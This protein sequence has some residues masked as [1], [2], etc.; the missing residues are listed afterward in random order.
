MAA[1]MI[2]D[3]MLDSE[4]VQKRSVPARWL[5]L[6][7]LLSADDVG[8]FE[9]SHFKLHRAAA[10]DEKSIPVL[11][12][13]LAEADLIRPYEVSG[14]QFGFIPRFRQRLQIKRTRYPTPPA[15][16]MVDDMDAVNKI[17]NL[18]TNPPLGNGSA[19]VPHGKTPPEP[20]PEPEVKKRHT[21]TSKPSTALPPC[22]YDLIVEQYH[23]HL[24]DLPSVQ[25]KEGKTW[26]K[27]Q[28]AMREFWAFVLT[29]HRSDGERRATDSV[30]AIAWIGQYFLR[31]NN[32]DFLMGRTRR[33]GE[34]E[35]W[36]C[37]FDFLLTDKGMA[38]VIERTEERAAS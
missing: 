36:K 31:V 7:I 4:R 20:E 34:H 2:R 38:H 1:R 10:L 22:P 13:E 26:T 24:P 25:L 35:N 8:L 23:Q 15:A 16:L 29:S 18:A 5:Y 3:D 19:T 32:N 17:N 21:S 33:S 11:L 12:K 9:V 14:K 30:K 37:T 27:R 6:T 28:K